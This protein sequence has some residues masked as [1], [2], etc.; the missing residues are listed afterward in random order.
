M[1][2]LSGKVAIVTG[3]SVGRELTRGFLEA[4]ANVA[5]IYRNP[6]RSGELRKEFAEFAGTFQS[7]Q[8]DLAEPG[9]AR[10]AVAS[11]KERFGG[12]DFLLNS[13]GGWLGGKKLHEHTA[14]ELQNMISMDLVPTFNIMSAVLPLMSEQN[15]G[16]VVN[17]ISMQV[18]GTGAGNSVYAAS[19]AA[20]LSLSK[21]ASEEYKSYGISVYTVAPSTIDT[22]N[23]RKSM[24]NADIKK[25][26]NV[27]E[28]V[29]A[30]LFVCGT[31]DSLNGTI[32]KF[33]GKL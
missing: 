20:V 29:A 7:V 22:P 5:F 4:G 28:I 1:V 18:F 24:P 31:G 15:F 13:L 3:G 6:G 12:V 11:V 2:N 17:F 16:R 30:L 32:L 9:Q 26:V 19:K 23:N 25:W 14:E 8:A 21:A 10:M 33:P 27:S